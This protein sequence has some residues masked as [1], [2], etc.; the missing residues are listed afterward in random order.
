MGLFLIKHRESFAFYQI[1][2][3]ILKPGKTGNPGPPPPAV[4]KGRSSCFKL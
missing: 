2:I 4:P 3:K 1:F